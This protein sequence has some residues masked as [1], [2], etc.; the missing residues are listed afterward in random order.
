MR[1][2]SG[3]DP[4]GTIELEL[5]KLVYSTEKAGNVDA[6]EARTIQAAQRAEP[7][8]DQTA[9]LSLEVLRLCGPQRCFRP[10]ATPVW[11]GQI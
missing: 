10:D 8:L 9:Q 3:P 11:P 6:T 1:D 7:P 5:I 2:Q 4:I